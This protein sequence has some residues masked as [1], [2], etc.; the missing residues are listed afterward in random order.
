MRQAPES[1]N[2]PE[3]A[4]DP[5][6]VFSTH[7]QKPKTVSKHSTSSFS[8]KGGSAQDMSIGRHFATNY[9]ESCDKNH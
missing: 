1:T 4:F 3:T 2:M 9:S 5:E 7:R 6:H 8:S